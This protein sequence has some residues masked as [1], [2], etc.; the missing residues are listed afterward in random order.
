MLQ[1]EYFFFD[2]RASDKNFAIIQIDHEMLLILNLAT[3]KRYW[4][5]IGSIEAEIYAKIPDDLVDLDGDPYDFDEFDSDSK[6]RR[7]KVRPDQIEINYR[8]TTDYPKNDIYG[9]MAF[10]HIGQS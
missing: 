10:L 6:I 5:E 3:K 9:H 8:I 1:E 7:M 4:T 2:F